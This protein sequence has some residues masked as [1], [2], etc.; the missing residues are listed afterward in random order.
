[1]SSARMFVEPAAEMRRQAA[2]YPYDRPMS[3]VKLDLIALPVAFGDITAALGI[4]A[5]RLSPAEQPLHP[6]VAEAL[7]QMNHMLIAVT[8]LADTLKQVVETLH[9]QELRRIENPRPNEA[10]WDLTRQ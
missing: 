3:L 7:Y 5:Q 10:N 4:Y 6:R 1:M 9:P 2:T 8:N